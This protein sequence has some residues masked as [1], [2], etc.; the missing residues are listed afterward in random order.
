M[1]PEDAAQNTPRQDK[2]IR[3]SDYTAPDWLVKET[4]LTFRLHPT[5][6]RVLSEIRFVR[7]PAK[8]GAAPQRLWR[9]VGW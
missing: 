9:C 2:T 4:R 5:A 6:T 8:T 3:L 1:R 7:N